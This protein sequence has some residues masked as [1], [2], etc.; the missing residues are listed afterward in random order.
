MPAPPTI[1]DCESPLIAQMIGSCDMPAP[2]L[3]TLHVPTLR[4]AGGGIDTALSDDDPGRLHVVATASSV[5]GAMPVCDVSL[6]PAPLAAE[7]TTLYA[8][9]WQELPR[10]RL[11]R[12]PRV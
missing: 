2:A 6:Y 4:N 8:A 12:P 7:L 11:D 9:R 5:D 3:P 1:L 10:S